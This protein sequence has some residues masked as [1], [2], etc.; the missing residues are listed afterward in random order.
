[1]ELRAASG[2]P[3]KCFFFTRDGNCGIVDYVYSS[4][5]FCDLGHLMYAAIA[6]IIIENEKN[7]YRFENFTREI[8]EKLEGISFVPTSQS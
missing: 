5:L 7:D 3:I 4:A 2:C 1:M 6:E 8:C